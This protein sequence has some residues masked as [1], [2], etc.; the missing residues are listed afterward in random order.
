MQFLQ[1]GWFQSYRKLLTDL[2]LVHDISLRPYLRIIT[3]SAFSLAIGIG[4]TLKNYLVFEFHDTSGVVGWISQHQY[5]KQQEIFYYLLALIGIPITIFLYW[6]GWLLYSKWVAARTSK[7]IKLI[8]K[9]YALA[10]LPLWLCW[11]QLINY[12]GNSWV[13]LIPPIGLSLILKACLLIIKPRS[14]QVDNTDSTLTQS[15]ISSEEYLIPRSGGLLLLYRCFAYILLPVFIYLL[16]YN[17]N[18]NGG[19]D[20]FHEGERVA[21]LNEMLH[22]GVV[23]KDIYVQHG[24]FQ[25]AYLAWFGSKFF[26]PT[27]MGVRSMERVLNPLG[28]V[29]LY[30]LGL[31]IFRVGLITSFICFLI[32]SGSNFSVS[33]RH[34]LGLLAFAFIAN[35]LTS[36]RENGIFRLEQKSSNNEGWISKILSS[37]RKI[38]FGGIFTSLAFWYS[39]EIGLY[40]LGAIGLFLLI[41]SLQREIPLNLR[42][43]PLL[44]Y[45]IGIL[46]GFLPIGIYFLAHGALDDAIWNSYIQCKYQLATWGLAFPSLSGTLKIFKDQGWKAFIL[47]DK[48]RWYLPICVYVLTIVYLT[49]KRLSSNESFPIYALK[50]LLILLGGIAFFRTALGRSDG[51]HL[52]F[53]ATFLWILCLFPFDR[54]FSGIIINLFKRNTDTSLEVTRDR[55][56]KQVILKTMWIIIPTLLCLWYVSQVHNPLEI[57]K[58][59]WQHVLN[60]PFN[61]TLATEEF[62]R[63]GQVDVPDDQSEQ[64][65]RVVSYIQENTAPEEKIFDFTSQGAYFFFAN[66]PSVTRY[67]MVC[68]A[69]TPGMQR[70]VVADLEADQTRLVIFKTGGWFDRIDGIPVEERHP[71]IAKYLEENYELAI[72]IN[73][74]EILMRK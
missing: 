52:H 27:L 73:N 14:T 30:L 22:G 62:E 69:S 26:G 28:Y 3:I 11:V 42:P 58:G 44:S 21:P 45:C 15:D 67:F 48:F 55:I 46:L 10:S 13:W 4:F 17:G 20:M 71:I 49:Y 64:I 65:Q 5:P 54:I 36:H 40:T 19:I 38:I 37:G 29:A 35:Y 50:L 63:A 68:Y 24:L 12:D 23:F 18:I 41:Y 39:T 74:T 61:R 7:P 66:R 6:I 51:G 16:L 60:N 31:Q 33:A 2:N 59:R 72:D 8:L 53:G 57:F 1:L 70:E 47:S 43:L 32:S 56:R 34:T 25:N 9:Q